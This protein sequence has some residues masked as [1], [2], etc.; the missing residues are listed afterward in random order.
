MG[1]NRIKPVSLNRI[2]DYAHRT[3]P[4]QAFFDRTNADEL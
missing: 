2:G 1:D 3:D 4:V